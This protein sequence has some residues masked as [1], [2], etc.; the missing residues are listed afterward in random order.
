M[1]KRSIPKSHAPRYFSNIDYPHMAVRLKRAMV[2]QHF[3]DIAGISNP[4]GAIIKNT[5]LPLHRLIWLKQK[6]FDLRFCSQRFFC[7]RIGSRRYRRSGVVLSGIWCFFRP[8][9]ADKKAQ[10][11]RR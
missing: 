11:T 4:I 8:K 3:A 1:A 6:V 5:D 2:L 9:Q 7:T 10:P